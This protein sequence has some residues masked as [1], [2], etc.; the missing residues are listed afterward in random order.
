MVV[1]KAH[2]VCVSH[3]HEDEKLGNSPNGKS[4]GLGLPLAVGEVLRLAEESQRIYEP[5]SSEVLILDGA[6]VIHSSPP[7]SRL[8]HWGR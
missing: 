2:A 4:Q 1:T 5:V 3:L 6:F 8:I 7:H